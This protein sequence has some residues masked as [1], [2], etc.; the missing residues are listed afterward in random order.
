MEITLTG[1]KTTDEVDLDRLHHLNQLKESLLNQ[2]NFAEKKG[3]SVYQTVP[4]LRDVATVMEYP[5]FYSFFEKYL[6]KPEKR[7]QIL[8]LLK[9]YYWISQYLPE[10]YNAY[11]KLFIIYTLLNHPD[12]S[13]LI[14]KRTLESNSQLSLKNN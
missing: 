7:A 11:H 8:S 14:F 6:S 12:Y 4:V 1:D 9:V 10:D 2:P 3:I 13:R 5:E